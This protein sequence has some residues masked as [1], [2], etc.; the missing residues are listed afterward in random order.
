[1]TQY[2]ACKFSPGL[3]VTYTYRNDGPDAAPGDQV[4]VAMRGCEKK[5]YVDSIVPEPVNPPFEIK[6]I[7]SIIPQVVGGERGV[8]GAAEPSA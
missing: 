1:M 3:A 7:L 2:L 8:V 4:L 5:L 6:A